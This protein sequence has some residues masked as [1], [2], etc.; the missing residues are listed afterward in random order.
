MVQAI[1]SQTLR[2]VTDRDAVY[3]FERRLMALS[4]AHDAL[5]QTSWTQADLQA[6]A[7]TVIEAIGFSDR[8][9]MAGLPVAL[10]P[11]AALSFSLIVHELLTNACKYGALTNDYGKVS[12]SWGVKDSQD[13]DLL[14]IEWRERGRPPVV[15]P[16]R[17]GF[18]SKLISIGL[19]GTGGV[20]LRFDPEGLAADLHASMR[21]LVQA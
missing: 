8:V 11:R 4:A 17:K 13:G 2:T 15:P 16:T 1:A 18:G 6:V 7:A 5:L 12:L 10:G 19:V 3:A 20:D 21:Q 9:R 14:K